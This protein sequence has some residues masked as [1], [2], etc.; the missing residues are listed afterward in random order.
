MQEKLYATPCGKI[1][2]WVNRD[3]GP[4]AITLVF[5]PGLTAD[6]RLFDK[7]IACFEGKYNLLVWDAPGHAASWPFRLTFS[8]MDKARWLDEILCREALC[9]PVIVGQ[10]M[11]GYVGQ[12]YAELP[13]IRPLCSESM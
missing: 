5:L 7:Q 6:H 1:H 8:L 4:A 10:S 13:L 2:Y 12:A 9:Q 11:G 3:C